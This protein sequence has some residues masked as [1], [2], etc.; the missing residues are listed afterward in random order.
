M[1]IF[2]DHKAKKG[3]RKVDGSI[4]KPFRTIQKAL[5]RL[6]ENNMYKYQPIGSL[7]HM[8]NTLRSEMISNPSK[9]YEIR[10]QMQEV[11]LHLNEK[12]EYFLRQPK[13]LQDW[14]ELAYIRVYHNI[15]MEYG[16]I[17]QYPSIESGTILV[18]FQG[19][20]EPSRV[21]ISDISIAHDAGR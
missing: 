10:S 13:H 17:C 3:D 5:K 6:K 14:S 15:Q 2:V 12:L 7:Q 9:R 4:S 21:F 20:A 19:H 11:I 16:N 1:M 8:L 18:L